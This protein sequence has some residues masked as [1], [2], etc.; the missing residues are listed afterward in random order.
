[1]IERIRLEALSEKDFDI[2]KEMLETS[3]DT[4][5]LQLTK[6]RDNKFTIVLEGKRK[7]LADVVARLTK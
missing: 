7:S 5:I 2:V 1:M 3:L 6:V 4:S